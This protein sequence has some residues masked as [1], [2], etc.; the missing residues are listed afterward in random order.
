[1]EDTRKTKIVEKYHPIFPAQEYEKPEENLIFLHWSVV[2]V[3][4]LV[5]FVVLKKF[6]YVADP[7]KSGK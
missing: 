3:F 2:L 6:I 1:M 4:L 5:I 7:K